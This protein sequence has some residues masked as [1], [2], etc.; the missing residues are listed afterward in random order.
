VNGCESVVG[1]SIGVN[2]Y[3][4]TP[5]EF[6]DDSTAIIVDGTPFTLRAFNLKPD[7]EHVPTGCIKTLSHYEQAKGVVALSRIFFPLSSG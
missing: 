7:G 6:P 4:F 5:G 3:C 2:I 1:A